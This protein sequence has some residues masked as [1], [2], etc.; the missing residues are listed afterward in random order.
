MNKLN[1]KKSKVIKISLVL[2]TIFFICLSV[3]VYLRFFTAPSIPAKPEKLTITNAGWMRHNW[4]STQK[5]PDE[6]DE[7]AKMLKDMNIGILYIHTGPI[8]SKG[9]IPTTNKKAWISNRKKLLEKLPDLRFEAWLGGINQISYGKAEDTLDLTDKKLL[10]TIAKRAGEMV[11]EFCFDGVHYDI[12]PIPDNDEGFLLLLDLTKKQIGKGTLSIS[13]PRILES[14]TLRKLLTG[15]GGTQFYPWS[16]D[17]FRKAAEKCDDIAIMAYDSGEPTAE[18]YTKFMA[19][20]LKLAL[21]NL[22]GTDCRLFMGIPTYEEKTISHHPRAENAKS[23]IDGVI[24]GLNDFKDRNLTAQYFK[25]IAVYAV[26]TTDS[27][28]VKLI[29]DRWNSNQAKSI[30]PLKY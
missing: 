13:C 3:F 18:A 9:R 28:E 5:S 15:V 10:E 8:D 30:S 21:E 29:K 22:K 17:Y 27:S 19:E 12:E 14:K 4:F 16:N 25:G 26:W 11:N 1:K 20:Q 7:M 23:G 2:F 6:I 24:L